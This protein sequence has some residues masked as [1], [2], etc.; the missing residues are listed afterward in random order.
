MDPVPVPGSIPAHAALPGLDLTDE[1][2]F[3]DIAAERVDDVIQPIVELILVE[4][5]HAGDRTEYSRSAVI[6]GIRVV[7]E[8]TAGG[9]Q[10]SYPPRRIQLRNDPSAFSCCLPFFVQG[11][12]ILVRSALRR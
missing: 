9:D 12:L 10:R 4:L 2:P 1:S 6:N 8:L 11:R 5:G 3:G 7:F